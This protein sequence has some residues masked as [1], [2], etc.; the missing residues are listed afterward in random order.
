MVCTY[1]EYRL[2]RPLN[3][4][5]RRRRPVGR[6]RRKPLF[7]TTRL[8]VEPSFFKHYYRWRPCA[9][10]A[11]TYVQMSVWNGQQA[12]KHFI[13]PP[14]KPFWM[15]KISFLNVV[16]LRDKKQ[17][18]THTHMLVML[19]TARFSSIEL[20]KLNMNRIR[21]KTIKHFFLNVQFVLV[22]KNDVYFNQYNILRYN[23]NQIISFQIKI[24]WL[25]RKLFDLTNQH[26][27]WRI[28]STCRFH[29]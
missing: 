11:A 18:N 22:Y 14:K 28:L 3:A 1:G 6:W 17:P 25:T 21:P 19:Q 16:L 8:P 7:L 23:D 27:F 5:K 2:R 13:T 26:F 24:N 20:R 15:Y 12:K 9:A 10:H 4:R 29:M